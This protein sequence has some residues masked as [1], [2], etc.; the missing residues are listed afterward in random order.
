[1]RCHSPLLGAFLL[2]AGSGAAADVELVHRQRV[3]MG[4]VFDIAAY[5]SRPAQAV[6]AMDRAL[7]EVARLDRVMSFYLPDSVLARASRDARSVTWRI[8]PDLSRLIEE[9]LR[10]HRLSEGRFDVTVGAIVHARR[11]GRVTRADAAL[12]ER[13]TGSDKLVLVPPDGMRVASPC[14][15]IDL[16]AI[17]KGYAVDRVVELLR[18]EGFDSALVNAGRSTL[19]GLG[20][21]PGE[22][23]WPV[24]LTPGG[25]AIL[26]RDDSLSTSEQ[27]G[28]HID[29]TTL[30]P[31]E[32]AAVS[33]RAPTATA[34]D[35]LSTTLLVLGPERGRRVVAALAGTSAIWRR[36]DGSEAGR[37]GEGF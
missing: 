37:C 9:S 7:D 23:G 8:G 10:Y 20:A 29:P 4:T 27:T 14:L 31:A 6:A 28:T 34:S 35:A 24:E 11:V 22:K 30:E 2:L 12:L 1:M 3:R 26:L 18:T 36:R 19:Y 17:G 13:C 33:V 15:E 16:G 5:T 25:R 32:A 21:P